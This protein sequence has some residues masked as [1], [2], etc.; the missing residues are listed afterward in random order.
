MRE[1]I[2]EVKGVKPCGTAAV[3]ELGC[4]ST[5]TEWHSQA[6]LPFRGSSAEP[7]WDQL[8]AAEVCWLDRNAR[9]T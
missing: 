9:G 3:D 1:C 5:R 4:V 7:C 8:P 6:V 2:S